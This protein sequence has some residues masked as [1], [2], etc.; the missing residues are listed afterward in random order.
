MGL[1]SKLFGKTP[2]PAASFPELMKQYERAW[3]DPR[4]QRIILAQAAELAKDPREKLE[5]VT[6]L[7]EWERKHGG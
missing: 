3:N 4:Q 5:V 6:R 1:F 7:N 2:T